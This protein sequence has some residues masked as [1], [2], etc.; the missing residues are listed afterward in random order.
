MVKKPQL[1]IIYQWAGLPS[2]QGVALLIIC[3][4]LSPDAIMYIANCYRQVSGL[5]EQTL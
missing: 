2:Q 5:L 4:K 3:Y 1:V